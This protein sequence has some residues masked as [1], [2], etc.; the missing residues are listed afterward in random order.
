VSADVVDML[1]FSRHKRPQSID[2]QIDE[3]RTL[4]KNHKENELA[5]LRATLRWERQLRRKYEAEL[6]R[7]DRARFPVD[8]AEVLRAL[9]HVSSTSPVRARLV[10]ERLF[11]ADCPNH[12]AVIRVG[13]AL[14]RLE[15]QGK[16]R[17]VDLRGHD[18]WGENI[19]GRHGYQW[20]VA[21]A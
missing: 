1:E 17:R 2:Q 13:H 3:L 8:D 11:P 10:A 5:Q 20:V 6:M 18:R 14:G 7:I 12:S 15:R 16:V 21:D 4:V 9:R 19:D